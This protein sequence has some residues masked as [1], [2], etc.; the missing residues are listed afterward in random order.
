MKKILIAMLV[1]ITCVMLLPG[2]E[3]R[4]LAKDALAEAMRA[5]NQADAVRIEAY[6]REPGV[7]LEY[8][9]K[10]FYG[11]QCANIAEEIFDTMTYEV[12]DLK[13]TYD[14]ANITVTVTNKDLAPVMTAFSAAL[15]EANSPL[16]K[17]EKVDLFLDCYD[18]ATATLSQKFT[19]TFNFNT[20]ADHWETSV[21]E[22]FAEA[23]TGG[24]GAILPALSACFAE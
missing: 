2:C 7:L 15:D 23:V 18:D 22:G 13:G 8:P 10:E 16:S 24:Y 20:K 6:I 17:D 9:D 5:V 14:I 19:L 12:N 3:A 4:P 21:P 1:V 11:R